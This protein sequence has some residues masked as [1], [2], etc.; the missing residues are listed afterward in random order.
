[1]P[2]AVRDGEE[3][4]PTDNEELG[5]GDDET[6]EE[7]CGR[8]SRAQAEDRLPASMGM[9]VLLPPGPATDTI[10][11]TLSFAE[12]TIEDVVEEGRKR[13]A[14]TGAAIPSA[15]E[16]DYRSRFPSPILSGRRIAAYPGLVLK[17]KL[18]MAEHLGCRPAHARC[19]CS[20][21][22]SGP[23]V[24]RVGRTSSSYSGRAIP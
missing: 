24:T 22:T 15:G 1:M 3:L 11:A 14:H 13:K 23:R 17:G 20:W 9:S 6:K 8:G 7:T 10:T 2:K 16:R 4:D 18:A 12:Y 19:P 21:S 5:A